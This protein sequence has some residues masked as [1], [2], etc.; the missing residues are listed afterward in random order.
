MNTINDARWQEWADKTLVIPKLELTEPASGLIAVLQQNHRDDVAGG[1]VFNAMYTAREDIGE[2][3]RDILHHG[4][5]I[6]LT[7]TE[8]VLHMLSIVSA[9]HGFCGIIYVH[10]FR[11]IQQRFDATVLNM[12]HVTESHFRDGFLSPKALTVVWG[13]QSGEDGYSYLNTV[14]DPEVAG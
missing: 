4:M 6:G 12:R 10:L 8:G 7:A 9:G 11:R 1:N 13:Q 2:P 5:R 3:L 14:V